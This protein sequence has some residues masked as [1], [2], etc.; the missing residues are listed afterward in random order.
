MDDFDKDFLEE[1]N[2]IEEVKKQPKPVREETSFDRAVKKIGK[3]EAKKR[4]KKYADGTYKNVMCWNHCSKCNHSFSRFWVYLR[5]EFEEEVEATKKG[6]IVCPFC[7]N[8]ETEVYHEVEENVF[9]EKDEYE[10]D[11]YG[12]R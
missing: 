2:R 12:V 7:G 3:E 1:L 10:C 6:E 9:S 4:M 8:K 11:I 5:E